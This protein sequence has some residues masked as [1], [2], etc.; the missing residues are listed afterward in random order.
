MILCTGAVDRSNVENYIHDKFAM[1]R[2]EEKNGWIGFFIDEELWMSNCSEEMSLIQRVIKTAKG[3]CFV[4]G[5]GLGLIVR[6][7]LKKKDV[8]HIDIVEINPEVIEKCS[9]RVKD[10]RVMVWEGDAKKLF[11]NPLY[12]WIYFDIWLNPEKKDIEECQKISIPYL[13]SD[14][15]FEYFVPAT[16][17]NQGKLFCTPNLGSLP[18]HPTKPGSTLSED[19]FTCRLHLD[20]P[21][22]HEVYED[23]NGKVFV[24]WEYYETT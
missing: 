15:M 24:N 12:D 14:G 20:F 19:F 6:E 8:E 7:L 11:P 13:K 21:H 22:W 10:E 4:G 17:D 16:R 18:S 23:E 2:I 1:V 3:N 5:L 9:T